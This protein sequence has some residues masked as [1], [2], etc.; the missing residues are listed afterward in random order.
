MKWSGHGSVDLGI[1][2]KRDGLGSVQVPIACKAIGM[3]G[4]GACG[5]GLGPRWFP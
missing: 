1:A 2:S 3:R 4:A 5:I